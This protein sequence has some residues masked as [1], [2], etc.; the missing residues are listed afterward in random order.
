MLDRDDIQQVRQ[1]V[2]IELAE[3]ESALH[4]DRGSYTHLCAQGGVKFF[5][6]RPVCNVLHAFPPRGESPSC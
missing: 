6:H 4:A 1:A 2:I 5:A 3:V